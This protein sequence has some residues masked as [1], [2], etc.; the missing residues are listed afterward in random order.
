MQN[1]PHYVIY[2][3]DKGLKKY[4]EQKL[5]K[6]FFFGFFLIEIN[7]NIYI[8]MSPRKKVLALGCSICP[9]P[10]LNR[11]DLAENSILFKR[12]LDVQGRLTL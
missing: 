1:K 11:Q 3:V 8:T 10:N 9:L 5:L 4:L 2:S 6:F 12:N 7:I